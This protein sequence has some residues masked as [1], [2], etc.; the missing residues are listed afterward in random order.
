MQ[1]LC[2]WICWYIT[3]I[4]MGRTYYVFFSP[5]H[6]I[7]TI[8]WVCE[9]GSRRNTQRV[10]PIRGKGNICDWF[11]E[12]PSSDFNPLHF[13]HEKSVTDRNPVGSDDVDWRF[14]PYRQNFSHLMQTFVQCIYPKMEHIM[15]HCQ[16]H[17]SIF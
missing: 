16:N 12:W 11:I 17:F 4:E 5:E 8:W 7:T 6:K 1:C 13:F 15:I 14:M 3:C 10:F 2:R 9:E